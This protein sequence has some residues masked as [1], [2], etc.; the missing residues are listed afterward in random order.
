MR[1]ALL[2]LLIFLGGEG[3]YNYHNIFSVPV[4]RALFMLFMFVAVVIGSRGA[5]SRRLRDCD[6]PRLPWFVLGCGLVVSVFMTPFYHHQSLMQSVTAESTVILAYAGFFILLRLNPEPRLVMRYLLYACGVGTIVYLI[7]LYYFP[8]NPFGEPIV[9]DLSRG[10]PRIYAPLFQVIVL[11]VFYCISRWQQTRRWS[12]MGFAAIGYM[13]IVFS[14]TRQ[15]IGF[16]TV[17]A[18]FQILSNV[19]WGK[20]IFL[21][22]TLA[23]V[24]YVIVINLPLYK[25]MKEVSQEQIDATASGDKEDVRIGAWRYY[26]WEGHD[27]PETLLL[28]NGTPAI[29][30]SVWGARYDSFA[31]ETGY[32]LAD[33][34]WAAMIYQYGIISTVALLVIVLMAV[35]RRKAPDRR[36]LTYYLICAILQGIAAGVWVFYYQIFVNMLALYLVYRKDEGLQTDTASA[37]VGEH[38]SKLLTSRRRRFITE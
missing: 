21:G 29:G 23:L 6:F 7:N 22:L 16:V 35:F 30:K 27:D 34:S 15:L 38:G 28:G 37:G 10:M 17:L 25:A 8:N 11:L 9:K 12:W 13:L 19:S 18:F 31:E 32:F 36:Y 2:V 20:K 33:V 1:R 26:A 5:E 24:G 14:L 4:T 3:F